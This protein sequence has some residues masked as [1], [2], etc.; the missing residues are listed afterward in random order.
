MG[1][2]KKKIADALGAVSSLSVAQMQ[3]AYNLVEQYL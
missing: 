3:E 2:L 1:I